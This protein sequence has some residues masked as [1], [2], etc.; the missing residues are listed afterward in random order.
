MWCSNVP[1]SVSSTVTAR[2]E[3]WTARWSIRTS[4]TRTPS[5]CLWARSHAPGQR[6]S[7]RSYLNRMEPSTRSTSSEIAARTLH[8]AKVLTNIVTQYLVVMWSFM[9]GCLLEF[10]FFSLLF[11]LNVSLVSFLWWRKKLYKYQQTFMQT[12]RY[13]SLRY[14]NESRYFGPSSW[15]VKCSC[16]VKAA[17][18]SE[19]SPRCPLA[20]VPWLRSPWR[21]IKTHQSTIKHH[22]QCFQ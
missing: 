12:Q 13:S 8:R 14:D 17:D 18:V 4:Q 5:R 3:K 15:G 1:P 6:R 21:H 2:P 19:I 16:F 11:L 22:F 20:L 10:L 9:Y 7:W